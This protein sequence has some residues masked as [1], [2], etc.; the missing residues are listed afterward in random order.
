MLNIVYLNYAAN[1]EISAGRVYVDAEFDE[2]MRVKSNEDLPNPIMALLPL[3]VTFMLFNFMKLYIGF[4][5]IIGI[6]TALVCF[7]RYLGG[8]KLVMGVLGKGVAAACVLCLSSGALA[9]FGTV[10][11]ATE[12]F[13]QFSI[14][15]TNIQGPPLFI[16][17]IAIMLVTAIC[18]SGPAAIGASLPMFYDTFVSMGVSMSAVHRIAAFSATTLDTLPTNA[19]FIAAAGLARSEAKDSYKYVGMCTV[20]NTTIATAVVTLLLTLFPGLA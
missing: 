5:I 4:S 8:V 20:V 7:W 1:R 12:T 2:S 9:G 18:G 6:L 14:A 10:V 16:V 17:M 19:G 13:G 15:L 3:I 11:Q